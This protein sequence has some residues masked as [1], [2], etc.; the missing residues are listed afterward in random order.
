MDPKQLALQ[1]KDALNATGA[2]VVQPDGQV[3]MSADRGGGYVPPWVWAGAIPP[4]SGNDPD[5]QALRIKLST[6]AS[7]PSSI[8]HSMYQEGGPFTKHSEW[9]TGKGTYEGGIDWG[10]LL[11]TAAVG[12]LFAAPAVGAAFGGASA[13]PAASSTAAATA[14]PAAAGAGTGAGTMS[15]LGTIGKVANIG[16]S[17]AD[18]LG[19]AAKSGQQQ[20]NTEDALRLALYGQTANAQTNAKKFALGAP[21]TRLATALRAALSKSATPASVSFSAGGIPQFSGGI[22][23]VYSAVQ[24]PQYRQL[25]DRVMADELQSQMTG[26]ATGGNQDVSIGTPPEVGQSSLGDKL[27][28]YG[29]LS[30][31]LIAA[32]NKAGIFNQSPTR[33]PALLA[34][35]PTDKFYD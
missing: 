32:L 28:G 11:G 30:A 14:A 26:G 33:T 4:A 5:S 6:P 19:G 2:F 20:N 10:T 15:A 21:G 3:K 17:I 23:S 12:G 29:G 31:N 1:Y 25:S 13:A 34:Y 8:W 9:D 7:D 16:S 35:D 24:D 18:V 22:K 27:L